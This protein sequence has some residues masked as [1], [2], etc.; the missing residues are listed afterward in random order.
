M[1]EP[2]LVVL[3]AILTATALFPHPRWGAFA[4][5]D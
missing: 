2:L 1:A 3:T 5:H 4:L